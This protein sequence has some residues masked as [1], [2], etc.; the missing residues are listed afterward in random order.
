MSETL[1]VRRGTPPRFFADS[2][3]GLEARVSCG[4]SA[5]IASAKACAWLAR[6]ELGLPSV[7]TGTIAIS[8]ERS[9]GIFTQIHDP[10]SAGFDFRELDANAI[11]ANPILR[12]RSRKSLCSLYLDNSTRPNL[13]AMRHV[14]VAQLLQEILRRERGAFES[15]MCN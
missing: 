12:A 2:N 6:S 1:G 5:V 7:P 9:N 10:R 13:G 11:W 14:C 15:T 8:R 3:V 4:I